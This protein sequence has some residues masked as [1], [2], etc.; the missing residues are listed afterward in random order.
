MLLVGAA[1]A[2]AT[3]TPSQ[4]AYSGTGSNQISRAQG[5]G[6]LPFTGLNLGLLAIV[7]VALVGSGLVLRART[8][9][10]DV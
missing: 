2:L 8:R 10:D 7:A 4:N 1:P 3:G 6:S 5:N 9:S